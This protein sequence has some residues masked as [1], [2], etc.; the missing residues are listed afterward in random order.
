MTGLSGIV[1]RIINSFRDETGMVQYTT[2]PVGAVGT[3]VTDGGGAWGDGAW[4]AVIAAPTVDYLLTHL[5]VY[6]AS[7]VDVD[8]EVSI[9]VGGA[10][11]EVEIARVGFEVWDLNQGFAIALGRPVRTALGVRIAARQAN[12]A[13]GGTTVRVKL[14]CAFGLG[15]ST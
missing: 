9:G 2:L 1:N 7:V 5:F 13:G 14:V 3:Q 15:V 4:V 10:G 11:V 8:H 6:D 12:A